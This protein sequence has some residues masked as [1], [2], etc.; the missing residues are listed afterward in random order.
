MVTATTVMRAGTPAAKAQRKG[1]FESLKDEAVSFL[2]GDNNA[3]WAILAETVIGCV[4]I[5]GQLV[6]ARDIIKGL[7]EVS[8]APAS[9]LAW[10]NLITALIGLVP[11][12]GDA[13]KRSARA[14]KSGAM[15]IDEFLPMIRRIYK[16][17]PEKA[18]K[19]ALDLSKLQRHLNTILDNPNLIRQ[20][21]PQVRKSV[22]EIQANL[23]KQFANF[24]KEIDGWLAKGRKTSADGPSTGRANGTPP[25]KPSTTAKGGTNTRA[26]HNNRADA[27][28]SNAATQRTERFKSLSQKVL[29]VL[30]EHMADYHCQDI[31]GWG[32]KMRHDESGRNNAKLNDRGQLVALWPPIPRGRGIDAVWKSSGRKPYAV[33]EAKA[34][35]NP[36]KT[37]GALLGEAG[38]KSGVDGTGSQAG[39]RGGG[40]G[41]RGRSGSTGNTRQ[42]NGK[43]TQMSH[44][45]IQRRLQTISLTDPKAKLDLLRDKQNAYTRHVLFFS[46]P[47]AVAHAEALI[48]HTAGQAVKHESHAA[49]QTTNQWGDS[50]IEKV[51]DNR[52][53]FKDASRDRRTR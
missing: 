29:G 24:K 13:V 23:N 44:G 8:G 52:A 43:V 34:S 35:Y 18:L 22:D 38:D 5:L 50:D 47:H 7:I 10:F 20:L 6:D 31:K 36:L 39:G 40:A 30:G 25:A 33:I 4:P 15:H 45:W 27:N 51:V 42:T 16:G 11:G 1:W 19:E 9:P 21:S 14:L 3:P 2:K 12:G 53:G 46:I 49:H 37:L 48:L 17:D 41:G 28:K 32:G 26:D